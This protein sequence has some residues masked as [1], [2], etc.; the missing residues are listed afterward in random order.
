MWKL[1]TL[2]LLSLTTIL[3]AQT[4]VL[5][6]AGSARTESV[7]KKLVY[8]A[9]RLASEMGADVTFIDLKDYPIQLYNG[10]LEVKEGMPG[11]AKHI[12]KLMIESQVILIASPVHNGTVSALLKNTLDWASRSEQGGSSREAFKGK[13]FAI[14][15]AS[16]GKG[17]GLKGLSH[18]R[19]IIEDI[20]G[21]VIPQ[22]VGIPGAYQAFD[23]KGKLKDQVLRADLRNLVWIALG[24]QRVTTQ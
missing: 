3:S 12:R 22:Q 9:G 23:E 8:E 4:K 14:M 20:G 10:D 17:G 7:N 18:L 21:T 24:K 11:N 6:F 1:I 13:V 16:P 19:D 15:S 2:C 5:A